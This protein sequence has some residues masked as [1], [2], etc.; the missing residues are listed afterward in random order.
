M[1]SLESM[2]CLYLALLYCIICISFYFLEI[3]YLENKETISS[4]EKKKKRTATRDVI[5]VKSQN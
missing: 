3:S 2:T 5:M 1:S 4:E